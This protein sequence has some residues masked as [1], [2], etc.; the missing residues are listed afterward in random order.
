MRYP[1]ALAF[2]GLSACTGASGTMVPIKA[3]GS[4]A[5]D[6]SGPQVFI[7]GTPVNALLK[8]HG[9]L[10]Y[11][12]QPFPPYLTYDGSW[13]YIIEPVPGKEA[14]AQ[15]AVTRG[16][17]L[18]RH[19]GQP[20]ALNAPGSIAAYKAALMQMYGPKPQPSPEPVACLGPE[21]EVPGK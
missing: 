9:D 5:G 19:A 17:V 16:D 3:V 18:I 2:L 4:V 21:C 1:L 20:S 12:V 14:E 15:A 7:A 6:M 13:N 8:V 11:T 10:T